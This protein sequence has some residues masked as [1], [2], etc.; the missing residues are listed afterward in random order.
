MCGRNWWND[1]VRNIFMT[2]QQSFFQT[3]SR[4]LAAPFIVFVIHVFLM[5]SVNI[6]AIAPWFD[7][8]MHTFGGAAIGVSGTLLIRLWQ[9]KKWLDRVPRFIRII[10][11]IGMVACMA[12]AWELAEF[13]SDF[14]FHTIMQPSLQDTMGD[15]FFG[16]LGG[17]ITAVM[18]AY[19]GKK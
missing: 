4:I 13:L 7:I 15:L 17:S 9:E 3:V 11:V 1:Y 5:F 8:P 10:A 18:F 2:Y 19:R 16:M 6:Y 14:F 12:V